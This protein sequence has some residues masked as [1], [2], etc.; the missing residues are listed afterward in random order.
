MLWIDL[1]A[2]W[3]PELCKSL[4]LVPYV[5]V[6][7]CAPAIIAYIYM[8]LIRW[9]DACII[10]CQELHT[11]IDTKVSWI[12]RYIHTLAYKADTRINTL[13]ANE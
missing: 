1:Y 10:P 2:C 7:I 6:Y 11:D 5:S 3:S 12:N 9:P 8:C 13:V 4:F